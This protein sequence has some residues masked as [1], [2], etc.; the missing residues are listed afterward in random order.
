MPVRRE[1]PA[2]CEDDGMPLHDKMLAVGGVNWALGKD[3]SSTV[4]SRGA[5]VDG[6]FPPVHLSG[7]R[8]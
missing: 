1:S 2:R 6:A 7:Q 4:P 5:E 8:P 3:S